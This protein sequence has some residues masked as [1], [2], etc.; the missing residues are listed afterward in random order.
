MKDLRT[1]KKLRGYIDKSLP[2]TVDTGSEVSPLP[3]LDK[4]VT[5][6]SYRVPG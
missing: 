4:A 3:D 2:E 1:N 6:I 5:V